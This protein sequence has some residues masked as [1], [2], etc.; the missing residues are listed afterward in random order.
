MTSN[1]NR[2]VD[3]TYFSNS[4]IHRT[5]ENFALSYVS[6]WLTIDTTKVIDEVIYR[7]EY[8]SDFLKSIMF[9][10]LPSPP[11]TIVNP[12]RIDPQ[13]II[14]TAQTWDYAEKMGIDLTTVKPTG[15]KGVTTENDVRQE[16]LER[17]R[18][19]GK[20]RIPITIKK[21][22]EDE[23]FSDVRDLAF[24]V[25]RKIEVS[26]ELRQKAIRDLYSRVIELGF[27]KRIRGNF[28]LQP[29]LNSELDHIRAKIKNVEDTINSTNKT[30]SEI[31]TMFV[32][33]AKMGWGSQS[34]P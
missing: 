29:L 15:Q 17:E 26:E 7:E 23:R 31:R 22:V 34:K 33:A 10:D 5:S 14:A 1:A 27:E 24:K 19:K 8:A 21:K 9:P 30:V 20:N 32:Q 3:D 28:Q 16:F 4:F 6:G 11:K 2:K 25:S 18:A 13:K 12:I